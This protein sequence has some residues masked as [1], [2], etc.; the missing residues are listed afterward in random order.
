PSTAARK[1]KEIHF[2]RSIIVS[3]DDILLHRKLNK[4]QLIAYD[5]ITERIFSNKAGAFFI[6]GPGGTGETLLYRALL[7]IVRS[8]GYIALATTTSGVAAS[9][10]PG[11]RTAHSRFKIHIDIHEKPVATLAKKSHLQG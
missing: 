9:I 5:L 1:A 10:L 2:E 4:N 3:E 11:G 6:N 7:A 8:M